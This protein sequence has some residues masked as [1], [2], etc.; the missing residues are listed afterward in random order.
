MQSV[1]HLIATPHEGFPVTREGVLHS[2]V[3]LGH[4]CCGSLT[5]ACSM[6][7]CLAPLW[8][9]HTHI[10]PAAPPIALTTAAPKA[11]LHAVTP[12]FGSQKPLTPER[13]CPQAAGPGSPSQPR[14]LGNG[15]RS[16]ALWKHK[17][18]TELLSP[19][20]RQSRPALL[21]PDSVVEQSRS[22][23]VNRDLG[24]PVGPW[25]SLRTEESPPPMRTP[26]SGMALMT[27]HLC[28]FQVSRGE[29]GLSPPK[30][31]E[32]SS[33]CIGNVACP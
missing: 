32:K 13:Q 17:R 1:Q 21:L 19:H 33:C 12:C 10:A 29:G 28:L 18:K 16:P 2:T 30:Q 5:S 23:S 4:S 22:P 24:S 15:P 31:A 6:H 9:P 11:M 27:E 26:D 25:V 7:I 20:G 8:S 3:A 14:G